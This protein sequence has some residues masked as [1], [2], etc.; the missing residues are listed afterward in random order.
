MAAPH[1]DLFLQLLAQLGEDPTREGLAE[2]PSRVARAWAEWTS[3][4][5]QRPEDILKCFEDGSENYDEMVF[6]GNIPFYS[7]CEHHLAPFF[8]TAHVAYIP[9]GRVVGLSKLTR[10]VDVFAHRLQVQERLTRQ[11]AEALDEN[12]HP[13]GVAVV[14]RARHFCMESRGVRK[15]GTHTTTSALLGVFRDKPEVR[16]EFLSL[17]RMSGGKDSG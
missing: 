7:H 1:P 9:D 14:V 11:I 6:Q 17:A 16:A 4:Y 10:L 13:L 2:T 12:L 15:V 5:A 8:G 3:G